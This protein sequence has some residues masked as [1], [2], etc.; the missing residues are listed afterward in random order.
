MSEVVHASAR[1]AVA[2]MAMTG[3]RVFTVH[4]GL[5][6]Q[7]PPEAILKQ[8]ARGLL[9]RVP[10]RRRPAAIELVHWTYG[11]AGGAAFGMLPDEIRL[12]PWSGPAYGL[13][14]WLVFE[15]RIAPLVGLKQA[16]RARGAERLAV[17]AD[18]LLYG[19][20]LSE[21]RARPRE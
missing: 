14:V 3:M 9:R 16:R 7:T 17:A 12:R 10:K 15:L 5:V 19:W 6:E 8:R 2:A 18:H 11:A 20:I 4:V 21:L 13:V 1:G